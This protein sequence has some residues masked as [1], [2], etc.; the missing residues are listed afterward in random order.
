MNYKLYKIKIKAHIIKKIWNKNTQI[1]IL[2]Q[3]NYASMFVC[4]QSQK[5]EICKQ[6]NATTVW[7]C[8]W[9][10]LSWTFVSRN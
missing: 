9:W 5:Q 3:H 4:L 10:N 8:E 7:T 1:R 6:H 2:V